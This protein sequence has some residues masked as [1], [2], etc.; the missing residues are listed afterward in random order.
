M[1]AAANDGESIGAMTESGD[2]WKIPIDKVNVT[3]KT[4]SQSIPDDKR[5]VDDNPLQNSN[6]TD[7]PGVNGHPV[8]N[9]K[10]KDNDD[11]QKK[12]ADKIDV[13]LPKSVSKDSSGGDKTT[14]LKI[15]PIR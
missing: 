5:K 13:N 10:N 11:F 9:K 4:P 1:A 12:P 8:E 14:D 15:K 3:P 6:P 7:K 2:G